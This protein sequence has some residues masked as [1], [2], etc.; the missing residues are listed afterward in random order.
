M[1]TVEEGKI[2]QILGSFGRMCYGVL[3]CNNVPWIER[4][5]C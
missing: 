3:N 5:F 4:D 1:A 2:I